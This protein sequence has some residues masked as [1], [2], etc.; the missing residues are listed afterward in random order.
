MDSFK[1]VNSFGWEEMILTHFIFGHSKCVL[2][3]SSQMTCSTM[4]LPCSSQTPV[5]IQQFVIL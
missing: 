3:H 1:D 4:L 5:I 2:L